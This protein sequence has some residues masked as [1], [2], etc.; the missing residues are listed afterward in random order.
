MK[1]AP[2]LTL[3]TAISILLAAGPAFTA[4]KEFRALWVECQGSNDTLSSKAKITK[5][6]DNAAAANFNAVI[7]QVYRANMCWFDS[8]KGDTTPYETFKKTQNADPLAFLIDE[9]HKRGLEVHAWLNVFCISRNRNAP[10]LK[11]LGPEIVMVDSKGRSFLDYKNFNIPADEQKHINISDEHIMLDPANEKLREYNLDIVKTLVS[12]YRSLDGIHLD[13]IRYPYTVPYSPG[14]RFSKILQFGYTTEA[15]GRFKKQTGLDPRTMD[16]DTKNTMAWDDFRRDQVTAF[17]KKAKDICDTPQRRLKLSTAVICWADRAYLSAFQD[18]RG[19]LEDGIVDF[20][21]SMNYT[22]DRRFARYVSRSA[23]YASDKKNGYVGFQ[24]YMGPV[25]P[26]EIVAQMLDARRAGA[27]GLVL[28]SYDC[29]LD[30]KPDIFTILKSGIFSEK[31][32]TP[33]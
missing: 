13:F 24:A 1:T 19:W 29:I 26:A 33:D 12:K 22:K 30:K 6:L 28:F 25:V 8:P 4:E 18:W 20:T 7:V 10:V 15:I 23:I 17:V 3:L 9:A 14:S 16:L 27:K 5:M 21:V 11:D 32:E 2:F 31:A